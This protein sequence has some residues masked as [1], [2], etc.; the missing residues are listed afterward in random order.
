MKDTL[1]ATRIPKLKHIYILFIYLFIF[2][3]TISFTNGLIS[4]DHQNEVSC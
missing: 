4:T 3:K 2:A 1:T